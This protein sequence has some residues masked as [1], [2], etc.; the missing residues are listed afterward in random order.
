MNASTPA[1]G[2]RIAGSDFV[3]CWLAP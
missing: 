3:L 2:N 1:S